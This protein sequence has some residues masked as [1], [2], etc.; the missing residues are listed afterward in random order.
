MVVFIDVV[1]LTNAGSSNYSDVNNK[2]RV[3]S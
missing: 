1:T 2:A 3:F